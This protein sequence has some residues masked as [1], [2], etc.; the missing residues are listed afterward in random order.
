MKKRWKSIIRIKK[1]KKKRRRKRKKRKRRK[2]NS[3]FV[4]YFISYSVVCA[5]VFFYK[6]D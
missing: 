4:C 5:L 2:I 3:F 1:K 6:E